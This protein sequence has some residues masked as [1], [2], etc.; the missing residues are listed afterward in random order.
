MSPPQTIPQHFSRQATA[1]QALGSPLT[2]ALLDILAGLLRQHP[3]PDRQLTER[4]PPDWAAK[5]CAWPGDPAADALALRVAG[6]LH[7]VVLDG[8]A[9]LA[10]AYAAG[11]LDPALVAGTLDRHSALLDQYLQGPPQTND[12]LRSAILLGGFLA[13]SAATGGCALALREVGASAGLNL[14]WDDYAYD[15]GSWCHGDPMTAP[16]LLRADWLGAPPATAKIRLHSRAG[17]D[18][19]PIDP[20]DP[21]QRKRLLSYIW[22]DQLPRLERVATALEHAAIHGRPPEAI[23]AGDFVIRELAARPADACLVLYHTI[24]WQY[25]PADEQQ[26]I[27]EAIELAGAAATA[28][29]PLAWLRAETGAASDGAEL[30]LTL[31]PGGITR[32]LAVVDYHGR[33]IRWDG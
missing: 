24:V 18:I 32:Q 5:L 19:R 15:F 6:A 21:E 31:W 20:R 16:L 29:A 11:R 14:L 25:L 8:D 26:R 4:K 10:V 17:C 22:A 27:A 2:A 28:E 12:P 33:W 23:G 3:A 13:I 7:R 1:C 9:D 30:K